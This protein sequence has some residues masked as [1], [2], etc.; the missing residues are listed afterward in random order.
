MGARARWARAMAAVTMVTLATSIAAA[1]RVEREDAVRTYY[2]NARGAT[3]KR[4][5]MERAVVALDA[6]ARRIERV[7]AKRRSTLLMTY[8]TATCGRGRFAPSAHAERRERFGEEYLNALGTSLSHLEAVYAAYDDGASVALIME[9][10]ARWD[11]LPTWSSDLEKFV[12]RLPEDWTVTQLSALGDYAETTKLFYD[13]QRER[14]NAPGQSLTTLPKGSRRLSGTQAYLI[15]RKGMSRL[16]KAYRSPA[17]KT[18]VC[19]MTCVELEE[20]V[21]ADGV[22]LDEKYRVATPP[23]FV[24][25]SPSSDFLDSSRNMILSW[26]VSLSLTQGKAANLRMDGDMIR[27]VLAEGLKVPEH[28]KPNTF[29]EHFNYHCKLNHGGG[30]KCSIKKAYLVNQK[31][32]RMEEPALAEEAPVDAE[33]NFRG[34][35]AS[36][37]GRV[38]MSRRDLAPK[39]T[40][41]WSEYSKSTP[42][43]SMFVFGALTTFVLA[44]SFV[45]AKTRP[46]SSRDELKTILPIDPQTEEYYS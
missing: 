38:V 42:F 7:D 44:A 31:P 23:L 28:L 13:W 25:R 33:E 40:S 2:V 8:E 6:R 29:M 21:L 30:S 46:E 22:H 27:D 10:D 12:E 41:I 43:I 15:S 3:T 1:E 19:S 26:A 24:E 45:F 11:L 16:V 34:H 35:N 36:V 4:L 32:P 20:C 9:D 39:E 14:K 17:G 37:L 5:E 18:D